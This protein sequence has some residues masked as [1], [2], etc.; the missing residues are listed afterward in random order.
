M[1]SKLHESIERI[2]SQGKRAGSF[3]RKKLAILLCLSLILA[4]PAQA[5]TW[6]PDIGPVLGVTGEFYTASEEKGG[7][8]HSYVYK[9]TMDIDEMSSIIV[10]YA[11]ELKTRGFTAKKISN[12]RG[13]VYCMNF[14][15]EDGTAQ[16]GI[17]VMDK[18]KELSQGGKGVLRFVLAVPDSMD[19]TLGH[20]TSKLVQGGTRCTECNGSG[21]CRY[22]SGSGRCKYGKTYETCVIC[23]GNGVCNICDGKG[24]Y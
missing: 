1:T 23:N 7:P 17:A 22:C 19:F 5:A 11:E 8:Y 9:C 13:I 24:S 15:C 20:G 14:T 4:L 2:A 16:M 18:A 10:A 21:R 6:L 12:P 3:L